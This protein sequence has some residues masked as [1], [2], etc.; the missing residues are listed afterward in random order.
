MW[1]TEPP[2]PF[3]GAV[4]GH[5]IH[6]L[7]RLKSQV[8]RGS[9]QRRSPARIMNIMKGIIILVIAAISCSCNAGKDK[10]LDTDSYFAYP[11]AVILIAS[12]DEKAIADCSGCYSRPT[13]QQPEPYFSS[14]QEF[15]NGLSV[16]WE[17]VRKTEYGDVYLIVVD[18]PNKPESVTPVLFNGKAQMIV[19]T[20]DL[21]VQIL[22][23]H[24]K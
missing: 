16:T 1:T 20:K 3:T 23:A 22:P 19:S 10:P 14:G 8:R 17:F 5:A 21:T 13:P 7:S 9:V 2:N 15:E 6:P 12:G 18:R 4:A 24:P 11:R